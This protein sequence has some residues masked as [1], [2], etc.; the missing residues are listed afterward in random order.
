MLGPGEL[1]VLSVL[2]KPMETDGIVRHLLKKGV[3]TSK[4][5]GENTIRGLKR[6]G[7]VQ[8]NQKKIKATEAGK[9]LQNA[10]ISTD[11]IKSSGHTQK[12]EVK[13]EK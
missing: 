4:S 10:L 11:V 13:E 12:G 9:L 8:I 5:S 1:E 6:K 3:V 7:F 2:N